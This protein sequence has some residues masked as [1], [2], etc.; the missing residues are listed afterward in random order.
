MFLCSKID[1][2]CTTFMQF[3]FFQN[4]FM[5]LEY[6]LRLEFQGFLRCFD[7]YNPLYKYSSPLIL[8][9]IIFYK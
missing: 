9:Y 2:A 7:I 6:Y 1:L 5:Y 3:L 8:S 4:Y